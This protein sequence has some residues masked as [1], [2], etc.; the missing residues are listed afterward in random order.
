L[1]KPY[2]YFGNIYA[3]KNG[4]RYPD[5]FRVDMNFSKKTRLFGLDGKLKFQVINILDY[6]NVLL[7]NW[8]HKASP[9]EVEAYSMF[10]RIFTLGWEFNI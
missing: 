5:Y 8:N 4:A 6:Y 1:E 2:N 3:K 10:P 9:S 7:Y